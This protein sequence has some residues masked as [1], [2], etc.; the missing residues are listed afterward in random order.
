MKIAI[1][2][3]LTLLSLSITASAQ[4]QNEARELLKKVSD[5]YRSLSSYHF[6]C[7]IVNESR[8]EG[9]G[10]KSDSR[11]EQIIVIAAAKPN[12]KRA[13]VRSSYSGLVTVA[14]G[15]TKW[16]YSPAY[17]QYC[18]QATE[19]LPPPFSYMAMQANGLLSMHS[20]LERQA[21]EARIERE[22]PI[23]VGGGMTACIVVQCKF[24]M[25]GSYTEPPIYHLWIDKTRGLV[26]REIRQFKASQMKGSTTTTKV[27]YT[28]NVVKANEPLLESLFVFSPPPGSREVAELSIPGAA[29]RPEMGSGAMIGKEAIDFALKDLGG[30]DVSLKELRG[31]VVLINFW[32]SW[33]GPCRGEMPYLEKLHRELKG[34]DA[35]ILGI[36]DESPE[37]ARE[38]LKT[39]GYTFPT[40]VDERKEVARNYHV[41]AIPQVFVIG[42]DGKVV[43]HYVGAHSESDLRAALKKAGVGV[44]TESDRQTTES[45]SQIRGAAAHPQPC[46]PILLSPRSGDSLDNGLIGK[47]KVRTWEFAWTECSS[48]SEYHLYVIGPR[49]INPVIDDDNIT[50]NSYRR[51]FDSGYIVDPNLRGWKWKVRAKVNGE[52][53]E[54]SKTGT[55]DVMTV[56]S[57]SGADGEPSGQAESYATRNVALSLTNAERGTSNSGPERGCR[58]PPA[59]SFVVGDDSSFA[60]NSR[61]S[62]A[63]QPVANLSL[64]LCLLAVQRLTSLRQHRA[65]YLSGRVLNELD[66]SVN[67]L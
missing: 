47:S 26:L 66:L 36:D 18:K 42:R 48:A 25:S 7:L 57:D 37:V 13:E 30:R 31:K 33:C 22:E 38:F 17:N 6:E 28:Y 41:S 8:S 34:K 65:V 53:G 64:L 20:G 55:F 24:A 35:V 15:E 60:T 52:W 43:T 3:L 63:K 46:V 49:A 4:D 14:D 61:Q 5:A 51:T 9:A 16:V 2:L 21:L 1:R 59:A 19:K 11:S 40:L 23:N 39:H 54:W 10:L 29:S 44:Q 50:T 62:A 58:H 45:S 56:G 67:D 27:T 12:K 32:A